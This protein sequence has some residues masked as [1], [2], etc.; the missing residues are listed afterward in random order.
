MSISGQNS[1]PFLGPLGGKTTVFR[2]IDRQSNLKFARAILGVLAKDGRGCSL[3]DLDAF[4]SSNLDTIAA[5][6]APS[7]LER[8]DIVI[9]EPSAEPDGV[10]A[11][12]FRRGHDRPLL[13]DS[14][15]TLF[16]LLGVGN[17]GSASRKFTFFISALSHWASSNGNPV[18]ASIYDRRPAFRRRAPRSV[19]DAFDNT[20]SLSTKA[21]GIAFRCERGGAWQGGLFFLPFE[22]REVQAHEDGQGDK[23]KGDSKVKVHHA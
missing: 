16:Q 3:L 23:E 18:M 10:L 20:V 15:N 7:A 9:P 1:G 12:I 22:A 4:Y 13:I 19:A 6:L 14:A 5:D 2:L 11:A 8:I 17:P 21:G